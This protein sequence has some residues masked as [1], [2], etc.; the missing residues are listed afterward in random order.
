MRY[1]LS[2]LLA[3][4][5][6]CAGKKYDTTS[7]DPWYVAQVATVY[8]TEGQSMDVE[9][10]WTVVPVPDKRFLCSNKYVVGCASKSMETIFV[11][12]AY[13]PAMTYLILVHEYMHEILYKVGDPGWISW[14]DERPVAE[15]FD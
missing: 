15:E 1:L 14:L 5:I 11:S 4:T 3:L 13:G 7:M 9:K 8:R 6:G 2:F 12:I 10:T